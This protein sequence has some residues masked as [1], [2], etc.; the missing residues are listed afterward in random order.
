M[1]DGNLIQARRT[2]PEVGGEEIAYGEWLVEECVPPV[3]EQQEG[4]RYETEDCRER[5]SD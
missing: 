5:L 1:R 3:E 2:Y 4:A